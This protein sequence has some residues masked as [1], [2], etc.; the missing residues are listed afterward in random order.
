MGICRN[1]G[2]EIEWMRTPEGCTI[3]VDPE[4]VFII[5]N[6]GQDRFYTEEEG[7]LVGRR[8]EPEEVRTRE[9]KSSTPLGF[10]PHWNTCQG[11]R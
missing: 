5:G 4:P 3:P 11:R 1:C 6:E 10:V 2:A 7:V 9:Q 8:A